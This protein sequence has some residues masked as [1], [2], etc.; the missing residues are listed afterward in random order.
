MFSLKGKTAFVTGASRGIGRSVAVSLAQA[1]ADVA[2]LGRDTA[3]L[4]ETYTAVT[5]AGARAL[6]LPADVTNGTSMEAA[7]ASACQEF[8]KIDI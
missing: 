2:L 3:A 1:G 8:G 4:N 6:S 7:V 5:N